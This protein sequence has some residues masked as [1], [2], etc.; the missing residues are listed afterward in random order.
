[1]RRV[2][3]GRTGHTAPAIGFGCA[4]L[5][6]SRDEAGIAQA[7]ETMQA[8]LDEGMNFFDTADLYG[9]G[10]NEELIGRFIAEGT[11]D[12]IILCTKYGSLPA[13]ADGMP[14]V[15]NSPAHI[16]RACDASLKRLGIDVID[17]YYM[18]RRDPKVPIEESVGA[19]SRLVEAGKVRWL[20]LSEVSAATLRAAA[21][22]HPITALESEY[23]LWMR[24]PE[25]SVIGA[26]RELGVS[27]VP[28]S[29]LGRAFLTGTLDTEEF[30]PSDMRSKLPRFRGEAA[31]H[32]RRLVA[33]MAEIARRK[34]VT[35]A[36]LALAWLLAKSDAALSIIPI[37]GTRRPKY[38]AENAAAASIMLVPEEVAELE[39]LFAPDAVAGPR[40]HEIERARA[41]L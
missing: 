30:A 14:G 13:G 17:L 16:A 25:D 34:G 7:F 12:R 38:V 41:G 1:M 5:S 31:A 33:E 19:M 28:F 6:Q 37:P 24:E 15:D 23:S 36:Q 11:R 4:G 20:G 21:A 8:A 40:Y 9:L 39:T 22:V 3:L 29:P 10:H 2:P 26:C 27:F 32:N 18:H 35:P